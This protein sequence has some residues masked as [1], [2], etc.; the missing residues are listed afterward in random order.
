MVCRRPP[1][2]AL[3]QT[4]ASSARAVPSRARANPWSRPGSSP[5]AGRSRSSPR[6]RRRSAW[7]DR[8]TTWRRP[9]AWVGGSPDP[10]GGNGDRRR[11]PLDAD[12]AIDGAERQRISSIAK[13]A[14][15]SHRSP[16]RP[17]GHR[18]P[19]S[20]PLDPPSAGCERL[21][22]RTRDAP[23]GRAPASAERAWVSIVEEQWRSRHDAVGAPSI[24]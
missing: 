1:L 7:R 23:C 22:S 3:R 13:D 21:R 6:P 20:P 16:V 17:V 4:R 14:S 18:W 5:R 2:R 11:G 12:R 19:L 24:N 15:M 10:S 8:R 9:R